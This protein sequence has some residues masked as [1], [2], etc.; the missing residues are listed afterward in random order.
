MAGEFEDDDGL[1]LSR[2]QLLKASVATVGAIGM[3]GASSGASAVEVVSANVQGAAA[4]R[5]AAARYLLRRLK[6]LGCDDVVRRS[7]QDLRSDV[8]Q[9]GRRGDAIGG[10]QQ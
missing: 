9:C 7:R 4:G 10:A 2:R 6:Q 8:C 1:A 5:I 3:V